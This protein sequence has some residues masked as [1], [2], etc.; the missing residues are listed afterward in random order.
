MHPPL[1]QVWEACVHS[2]SL[3]A[4]VCVCMCVQCVS[5]PSQLDRA[6]GKGVLSESTP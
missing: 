4:C 1:F 6:Q 5:L 2:F 3:R